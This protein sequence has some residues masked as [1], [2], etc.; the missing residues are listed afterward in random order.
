MSMTHVNPCRPGGYA[1]LIVLRVASVSTMPGVGALN[2]PAWRQRCAAFRPLWAR[3]HCEAPPRTMLGP[4]HVE[5]VMRILHVGQ[6]GLTARN[7]VRGEVAESLRGRHAS[8]ASCPGTEEGHQPC[9]RLDHERP[10]TPLACLAALL[11]TLGATPLGALD[12]LARDAEGARG[13]LTPCWPTALCAPCCDPCCPGPIGAPWGNGV[14][15]GALG[16][17]IVRPPSPWAAAPVERAQRLEDFP[18]GHLTRAPSA[19]TL[20]GRW[21]HRSHLRP[22]LVRESRRI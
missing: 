22:W 12:R 16:K 18:P 5:V 14:R 4:P 19:L 20:L 8:I 11:P 3:R 6:N 1:A 7:I 9:Q 21:D 2:H 15:D 10:L 17:E 13:G